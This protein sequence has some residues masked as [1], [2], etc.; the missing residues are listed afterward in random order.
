[1]NRAVALLASALLFVLSFVGCSSSGPER[2]DDPLEPGATSQ[3]LQ[4]VVYEVTF[5]TS[6]TLALKP[7]D[8]IRLKN[9]PTD[10]AYSSVEVN[11]DGTN[12]PLSFVV[13]EN[14]SE[15]TLGG[16]NKKIVVPFRRTSTQDLQIK[17]GTGN[18]RIVWWVSTAASSPADPPQT[19]DPTEGPFVRDLGGMNASIVVD[20]AGGL[21]TIK[22][23]PSYSYNVVSLMVEPRD[24]K[25]LAGDLNA[26]GVKTPLSGWSQKVM[27]KEHG[28]AAIAFELSFTAPRK[29]ALT[30]F[31]ENRVPASR[32][33]ARTT[34]GSGSTLTAQYGFAAEHAVQN[35]LFLTFN[36]A[37]FS[38][39]QLPTM[40]RLEHNPQGVRAPDRPEDLDGPTY[41]IKAK[42]KAGKRVQVALPIP[43]ITLIRGLDENATTVMH[44][45]D[46][47]KV[48]TEIIPDRVGGGYIYF[49]T[50][51]FS[52]FFTRTLRR[53]VKV[54]AVVAVPVLAPVLVAVVTT[55]LVV[56]ALVDATKAAYKAFVAGVCSLMDF[57]TYKRL[58]FDKPSQSAP[59][60]DLTE[61]R[62]LPDFSVGSL[63]AV[64]DEDFVLLANAPFYP[65]GKPSPNAADYEAGK[66]QVAAANARRLLADL[67]AHE[68]GARRYKASG[69]GGAAVIVDYKD[70]AHPRTYRASEVFMFTSALF[71]SAPRVLSLV[72]ACDNALGLADEFKHTIGHVTDFVKAAT[73]LDLGAA[74]RESLLLPGEIV[75][76]STPDFPDC[77]SEATSFGA[78]Y[79]Q[80]QLGQYWGD[81]RDNH[82]NFA[83]EFFNVLA[84]AAWIDPGLRRVLGDGAN[85]L[86]DEIHSYVGLTHDGYGNN[87]I[88]I[89]A[90]AGVA[91]W[92]IITKGDKSTYATLRTWLEAKMGEQGGYAEGT[93]YLQYVNDDVPYLI[94]S[95][96]RGG[97]IS[98]SE[99]PQKYLRSGEWLLNMSR[100]L[101]GGGNSFQFL[102][103]EVDDGKPKAIDFFV[104]SYLTGDGRYRSF[105]TSKR[106]FRNIPAP[107]GYLGL[108]SDKLSV[109]AQASLA[110]LPDV[111]FADG[112]GVV[113]GR[114]PSGM[115]ATLSVIAEKGLMRE[116]GR[117]HDQQDNGS[118]TL[119]HSHYWNIIQDTGYDGFGKRKEH[120]F[121]RFD[122]HNV[123]MTPEETD[124]H[125]EAGNGKITYKD[126]SRLVSQLPGVDN[127]DWAPNL[128]AFNDIGLPL[129]AYVLGTPFP[130]GL[131]L[132]VIG[133]R[134]AEFENQPIP[135][136]VEGFAGGADA[137][138]LGPL[139]ADLPLHASHGL[140]VKHTSTA[141][142]TNRRLLLSFASNVWVVD[143]AENKRV[144][145]SQMHFNQSE[146]DFAFQYPG[147]E[148]ITNVLT[149]LHQNDGSPPLNLVQRIV[150]DG[151][152][153]QAPVFVTAVRVESSFLKPDIT[154]IDCVGAVCLRNIGAAGEFDLV[155]VPHWG[156]QFFDDGMLQDR[157]RT[158]QIVLAHREATRWTFRLVG[159]ESPDLAA[160][161]LSARTGHARDV[162]YRLDDNG[163]FV[164]YFPNGTAQPL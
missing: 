1:M 73:R 68:E 78:Y 146:E 58:F 143:R 74:C 83:G 27:F 127:L 7:G 117:A 157:V 77:L 52:N 119:T 60:P 71:A 25:P 59:K 13:T 51:S 152:D 38:D 145:W 164:A 17:A 113:R 135:G 91:L 19:P 84:A 82:I 21:F 149:G 159:D 161:S 26:G 46:V 151:S 97:F 109:S 12:V 94:S 33:I 87:N 42:L 153:T 75:D 137:D 158:G 66:W 81:G 155:I 150:A 39:G 41:D 148:P 40:T 110:T 2:P 32:A 50:D 8:V 28:S 144:L 123:V 105:A 35:D 61:L 3:S 130:T 49:T 108:P 16:W 86:R 133:N 131:S 128:A 134:W 43:E 54:V 64:A 120:K 129:F 162:V 5:N 90:M 163:A 89:K 125:G 118:I 101:G 156:E 63:Q 138:L 44:Y 18:A 154:Q 132:F 147:T 96:L 30:W 126:A 4:S 104:Y 107:L 88:M 139:V 141:G 72:V 55:T 124:F 6:A 114:G 34:T 48:W 37:D 80:K 136:D 102:P 11:F 121:A 20:G 76:W 85:E 53:A 56:D 47:T 31:V 57:D 79:S 140:E 15:Y 93:G 62:K 23:F 103:V 36:P 160:T 92:D 95:M 9:F 45:N 99:L 115:M 100:F 98:R 22:G 142:V 116:G 24:S 112:V 29:V 65:P 106:D 122:N 67:L 69:S 111:Y 14:T 70:A 10:W